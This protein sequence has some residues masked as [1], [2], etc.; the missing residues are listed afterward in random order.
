LKRLARYVSIAL[1]SLA[2]STV[3][4]ANTDPFD[5]DYEIIGAN[6]DRPDMVFNDGSN[7]YIQHRPGQEISASG[8]HPEG[9][10]VVIDGTPERFEFI[11]NGHLVTARW[12]SANSF[13]GGNGVPDAVRGDQ[14]QDFTGFS[15]RLALIGQHPSIGVVRAV[16]STMPV[17][18]LVKALAP[19]GWSGAASKDIDL[20]APVSFSTVDGESWLQALNRLM[21]ATNL[22]ASVDFTRERI[23]LD[24]QAPKSDVEA[25][26]VVLTPEPV[27]ITSPQQEADATS[28]LAS[29]FNATGI[30]DS[31]DTHIQMRF[32]QKPKANL[33]FETP[34]GSSLHP[35]WRSDTPVVTF[36]RAQA[37]VV[38]D[39][40][41][42]VTVDR[43][44]VTVYEFPKDNTAHLQGVFDANGR[45]FFKFA[46]SVIKISV[47]NGKGA[48][49]GEQRG[50]NYMYRGIEDSFK[51][52]GDG[53]PVYIKRRLVTRFSEKGTS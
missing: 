23:R 12:K 38:T 13:I 5:F 27:P 33:K 53:V 18:A 16:S 32:S 52:Q 41:S 15:D 3:H 24:R 44:V 4:A 43:D 14:P 29:W 25:L 51:A 7:T 2:V 40:I 48:E 8:G 6:T 45:T 30:R 31:D 47:V 46:P 36:D 26:A 37:F 1:A 11:S 22:Y 19:Q 10:Y 17:G 34:D 39:G 20:N 49:D 35:E 42:K 28:K 21:S 50:S 9:P